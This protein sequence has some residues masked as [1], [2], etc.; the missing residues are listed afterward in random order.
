MSKLKTNEEFIEESKLKFGNKF[1]Y[2]KCNYTGAYSSITL[3]CNDCGNE[4]QITPH[5]H[6]RRDGGCRVCAIKKIAKL[7][8]L[9]LEEVIKKCKTHINADKYDFTN[10]E[11]NGS[12]K[13][14]K[15]KC[16]E[17]GYFEILPYNFYGN[18]EGCPDCYKSVG[19]TII[20]EILISKKMSFQSQV[21][22]EGLV[23]QRKLFYDFYLPEH[24]ILIECNGKQHYKYT[25]LFHKNLH[26]FHRQLH[27]DWLK[28]KYA[29]Q[30][31]LELVV[32]KYTKKKKL[33]K[34]VEKF[35]STISS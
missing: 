6:L 22:F 25:E 33:M 9:T 12:H 28:R 20:R 7:K 18:W 32:F 17:H 34:E 2:S 35:L 29:K 21:N 27:H 1:N 10:I 8:E 5:S 14:M 30:H 4:F 19:E 11:W 13:N 26:N 24:K 23:D 16:R 15:L 31:S 3:V